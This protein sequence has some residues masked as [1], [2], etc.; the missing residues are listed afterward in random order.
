MR[1]A[2]TPKRT[3]RTAAEAR[4]LFADFGSLGSAQ[5]VAKRTRL[6]FSTTHP[7]EFAGRPDYRIYDCSATARVGADGRVTPARE[8]L[9]PALRSGAPA[10]TVAVVVVADIVGTDGGG[11]TVV[12][13]DGSPRLLT[14]GNGAISAD[15]AAQIPVVVQGEVREEVRHEGAPLATQ[16]R[17]WASGCAIKGTLTTWELPR[18]VIVVGKQSMV[19]VM[20][21][22]PAA[23]RGR[24]HFEVITT[25]E[26]HRGHARYSQELIPLLVHGAK[27]RD[28][29]LYGTE[30]LAE[31]RTA[32]M[33]A[34]ADGERACGEGRG[35]VVRG[36]PRGAPPPAAGG[37]GEEGEAV[38]RGGG[39]GG[40]AEH[41]RAA[42]APPRAARPRQRDRAGAG[43]AGGRRGRDVRRRRPA[44]AGGGD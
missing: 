38:G 31:R 6:L 14:D 3:W 36:G 21:D 30:S 11:A 18:G 4:Q 12:G 5:K 7:V 8:L 25:S 28:R 15:L 24:A 37:A 34:A 13:A 1:T 19:K 16:L 20:G 17:L 26:V 23:W 27:V 41:A 40:A 42:R 33:V 39:G 43:A 22:D 10:G 32:A 29:R 35:A 9:P 2:E 44:A